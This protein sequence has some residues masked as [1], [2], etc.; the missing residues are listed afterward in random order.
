MTRESF[1]F[2][3]SMTPMMPARTRMSPT[4]VMMPAV[5]ISPRAST[6]LVTLVTSPPVAVLSKKE[7]ERRWMWPNSSTRRSNITLWP[8]YWRRYISRYVSRPSARIRAK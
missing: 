5:N 3:Q 2:I 8:R 7:A 4:M 1:R 6:S